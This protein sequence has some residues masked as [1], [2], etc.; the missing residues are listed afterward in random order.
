MTIHIIKH[1]DTPQR[2]ANSE[3]ANKPLGVHGQA[4]LLLTLHW[5][6]QCISYDVPNVGMFPPA[7]SVT[8]RSSI[9]L[10]EKL[11]YSRP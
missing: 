1:F 5:K 2:I 3:E 9:K 8:V 11:Q 10:R 6:Q 4:S 7:G